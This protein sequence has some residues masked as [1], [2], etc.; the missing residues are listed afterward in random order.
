MPPEKSGS[1]GKNV[2]RAFRRELLDG[3]HM[4]KNTPYA[5]VMAGYG[6]FGSEE[7][8]RFRRRRPAAGQ[9]SLTSSHRVF[10]SVSVSASRLRKA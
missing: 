6:V 5:A 4:E 9:F 3:T 10:T 2:P 1:A 8:R 7:D